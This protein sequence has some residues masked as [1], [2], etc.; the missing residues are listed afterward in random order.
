MLRNEVTGIC[1]EDG[2]QPGAGDELCEW[3]PTAG[4]E[5]NL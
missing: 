3:T 4:V 2:A 1:D 5:K